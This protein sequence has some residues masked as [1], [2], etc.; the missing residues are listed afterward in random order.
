M[1]HLVVVDGHAVAHRAYHSIPPLTHNGQPVN[2][3]YGFYSILLS[4]VDTL[5]PNYLVVCLDS[6]GPTFRQSEYLA[7]RARRQP[8][9][10]NLVIQLPQIP[11]T[12]E[13][14]HIPSISLGGYEAD[15]LIASLI[16]QHRDQID[17]STIITGDQDLMQLVDD[18]TNLFMPASRGL[19]EAKIIGPAE[20]KE[21]LGVAPVQVIDLKALMGDLSDNY[22]GVPGIGPKAA[23]NLLKQFNSLDEVY[24]NID[25]I[26]P[27]L[28]GRLISYKDSAY[29][30]KKL[31]TLVNNIPLN[32]D[33]NTAEFTNDTIA[34]LLDLFKQYNFKSLLNRLK[35][36]KKVEKLSLF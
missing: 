24:S 1:S 18:Q 6:P 25:K 29:L 35:K 9:E 26:Q 23:V 33:L 3:L 7:Y 17:H 5:K 12:L 30:S 8:T 14:A 13:K 20:V 36:N 34:G 16:V 31:A 2:A 22:P 28:A 15:D 19:L 10:H 32:F 27:S 4:A 11:L 21:K